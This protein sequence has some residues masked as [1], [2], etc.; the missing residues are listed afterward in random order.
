MSTIKVNTIQNSSGVEQ[1]TCKAWVN[2]NGTGAVA[3]RANGNVSSITDSG[4]GRY[5]VNLSTAM[6][7]AN[8]VTVASC[9]LIGA[10]GQTVTTGQAAYS[11]SAV[12]IQITDA[13][14]NVGEDQ[15]IVNVAIFR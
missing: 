13:I 14:N 2:F 9:S 1:Y 7:D 6:P 4:T 10:G 3:I 11:A 12:S 15:T 5:I 8:Y